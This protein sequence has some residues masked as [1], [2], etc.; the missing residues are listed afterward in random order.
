MKGLRTYKTTPSCSFSRMKNF[1]SFRR[2]PIVVKSSFLLRQ[3]QFILRRTRTANLCLTSFKIYCYWT[4]W[5]AIA[6]S[7]QRLVTGWTVWGSNP[8][9][10]KIFRTLFIIIN[11]LDALISQI[12]F[13]QLARKLSV[14][15]YDIYHCCVYSEKFL[16]MDRG[17][18]RNM[19]NF[20]PK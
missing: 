13:G 18:V 17:T 1:A 9:G 8:G 5:A 11:Q 15:L 3:I 7:V 10:D 19:Q 2:L 6:R 20:L 12:Y 4:M 16:M 14:N